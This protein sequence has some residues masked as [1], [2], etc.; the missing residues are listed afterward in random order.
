M[1]QL[2]LTLSLLLVVTSLAAALEITSVVPSA[3]AP[4]ASVALTGGPFQEGVTIVVGAQRLAA[5]SIA[6]KRITFT[7]PALPAGDYS[8][9][10]V[11]QQQ[12]SP[13]TF[14]LRVVL[15]PPRIQQLNPASLD[16][17]ASGNAR[18]VS[19]DGA[20]FQPGAALLFDGTALPLNRLTAT[21]LTV[22][23]P[24]AKAGLHQLL[25]VNPDGQRSLPFGLVI[26]STPQIDTVQSGDDRVVDYDLLLSGKNFSYDSLLT[27]NGMA[28]SKT[29]NSSLS[30]APDAA[31]VN[32]QRDTFR[33]VDCSTL[34]YTRHPFIREA[35]QL[36][37]QVVNPGGE[38]SNV[39]QLTAP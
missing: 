5:T 14:T 17:C 30:A 34:L 29:P 39:Y 1:R 27:V 25:V 23:V 33:Y 36:S 38:A 19:V 9:A 26:D 31:G 32:V 20:N 7:V 4:G 28:I 2:L 24:G 22:T 13:H 35:H 37:L 15:P 12:T 6:P 16:S 8:L 10:V 21:T 18:Q 11:Q 3:V